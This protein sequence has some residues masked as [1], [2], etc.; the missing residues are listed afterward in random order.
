MV[1]S[2][3]YFEQSFSSISGSFTSSTTLAKGSSS[4]ITVTIP[5]NRPVSSNYR[6]RVVSSAPVLNGTQSP[7]SLTISGS[8][9]YG[10]LRNHVIT[11]FKRH[12]Q[13]S[14]SNFSQL[15]GLIGDCAEIRPM[16]SFRANLSNKL[17]QKLT[18]DYS[19]AL[20]NSDKWRELSTRK[21][22]FI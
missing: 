11:F 15:L 7:T 1:S 2:S 6:I 13:T 3:V 8:P 5:A 10:P 12:R 19:M 22:R 21:W 17:T 14:L 18:I 16:A 9:N 20:D 4:P